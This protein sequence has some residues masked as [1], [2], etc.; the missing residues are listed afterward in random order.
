MDKFPVKSKAR[1]EDATGVGDI[2]EGFEEEGSEDGF[3]EE[4]FEEGFE[5][6]GIEGKRTKRQVTNPRFV[7]DKKMTLTE[8]SSIR[9]I[10]K[11]TMSV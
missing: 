7:F 3:E 6:G 8:N 4:D 1:I 9:V 5:D 2:Q 11:G 10:L